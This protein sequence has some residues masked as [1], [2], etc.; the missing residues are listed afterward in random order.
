MNIFVSGRTN[1]SILNFKPFIACGH[2][3][4]HTNVQKSDVIYG[5]SLWLHVE[6]LRGSRPPEILQGNR[7]KRELCIT[8]IFEKAF[9]KKIYLPQLHCT[10]FFI[11]LL[12]FHFIH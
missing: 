1:V 8:N 3:D 2:S 9:S 12:Y 6:M 5:A 4:S 7:F 10:I 11:C